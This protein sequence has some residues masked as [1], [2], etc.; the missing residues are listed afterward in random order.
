MAIGSGAI[1]QIIAGYSNN[2]AVGYQALL[3][4]SG[5]TNTAIGS[6]SGSAMTTGNYNTIL[7]SFTGNQNG[8]DIHTAN[9]YTVLSDGAG[10]VNVAYKTSYNLN[11]GPTTLTITIPTGVTGIAH[12]NA[13]QGGVGTSYTQIPFAKSTGGTL[14]IGTATTVTVTAN[15]L[16]TISTSSNNIT[17][18]VTY[19]N[20]NVDVYLQLF[21]IY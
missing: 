21:P 13:V 3:Q 14:A 7:G 2:T 11:I 12:V 15:P 16:G 8:L 4:V 9:N 1:S 19:A 20:T 5:N 10:N 18:V 6:S 17:A